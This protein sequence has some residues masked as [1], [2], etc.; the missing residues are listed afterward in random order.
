MLN[1]T[2]VPTK[3]QI[4]ECFPSQQQLIR[5]KAIIECYEKIP[6]NPCS[7]SCPHQAIYIGD[8]INERPQLSVNRCT[9][10]GICVYHCPG[11]A[12]VVAQLKEDRAWFKIPYEMLPHPQKGEVW[13]GINRS[14]EII[15]D[16]LIEQV[17]TNPKSDHT[18][19][20][21]AS[22]DATYLYD[23]ITIRKKI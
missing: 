8:D 2:G 11:L 14:G 12:I 18:V 3:D 4:N 16:A 5:P 20:V 6:C 19:L 22:V 10:C 13:H 7:T 23:F 17:M 15:C 9:G 21:T 1:K